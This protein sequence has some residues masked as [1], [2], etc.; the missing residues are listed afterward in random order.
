MGFKVKDKV[1]LVDYQR[2]EIC[3]G[4]IININDFRPPE[5]RYCVFV[6]GQP[7]YLF[8]GENNLMKLEE[9]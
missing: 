2:K 7:D 6:K 9:K 4:E 8:V 3:D 5:A 1:M